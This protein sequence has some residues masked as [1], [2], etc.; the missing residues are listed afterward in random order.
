MNRDPSWFENPLNDL[1]EFLTEASRNLNGGSLEIACRSIYHEISCL[2]EREI[3]QAAY[4]LG[5]TAPVDPMLGDPEPTLGAQLR[6][7]IPPIQDAIG[8]R[9]EEL[10]GGVTVREIRN[11]V[12]DLKHMGGIAEPGAGLRL[13]RWHRIG[14]DAAS[15][16]INDSRSF[17]R[18]LWSLVERD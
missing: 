10:P 6:N 8:C 1:E 15:S 7:L 18:E 13:P 17:F 11:I 3:Q 5:V 12:N 16:A 14:A 2:F 4:N 9:L